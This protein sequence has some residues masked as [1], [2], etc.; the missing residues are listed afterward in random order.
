MMQQME[1]G[2]GERVYVDGCMACDVL[3]GRLKPPGGVI[4]EDEYWMVDHCVSPVMLR[5]FLIIKLK[6]HCEHLAELAPAEAVAFGP[7]MR[8]TCLALSRVL[9]PV[10]VYVCSFGEAV[11]HIHFYVIP[12]TSDMPAGSLPV[13]IHL[14]MKM[15]LYRLGMKKLACSDQDAAKVAAQVRGELECLMW[16]ETN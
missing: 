7:I 6:R 15:I 11:K 3:A 5:G 13:F 16:E 4:Y 12:R 1:Y 8:N 10:K 9:K 14:R 2:E